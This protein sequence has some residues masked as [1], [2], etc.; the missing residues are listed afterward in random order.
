MVSL[1]YGLV[2]SEFRLMVPS[3]IVTRYIKVGCAKYSM[4]FFKKL[5]NLERKSVNILALCKGLKQY[6]I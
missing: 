1:R 3:L 6:H 2:V 5:E 4:K